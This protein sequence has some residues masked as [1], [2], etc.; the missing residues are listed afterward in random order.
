MKK[1]SLLI[2]LACSTLLLSSCNKVQANLP[3][4][5]KPLVDLGE[6]SIKLDHN[7]LSTIYETI[8]GGDAY[9][10]TVSDLLTSAIAE[11]VLGD[12]KVIV[13]DGKI[14]VVLVGYDVAYDDNTPA[15]KAEFIKAHKAYNNWKSSSFK[16]ILEDG[17]PTEADFEKRVNLIKELIKTQVITTLWNEANTTSYKRNNRFYE[18]LFARN[19]VEKLYK[20]TDGK[21][22]DLSNEDFIDDNPSYED[23]YIR[24]ESGE[25]NGFKADKDIPLFENLFTNGVLI[26]SKYDVNSKEGR[27]H[28]QNVLHFE[29]YEDYINNSVM[30]TI[31]KN[32]LVEQYVLQ[33]QFSAIG[34]TA[35]RKVNFIQVTNNNEKNGD[36]FFNEFVK[37]YFTDVKGDELNLSTNDKFEIASAAWKGNPNYINTLPEG[38]KTASTDLAKKTFGDIKNDNPSKGVVPGHD[39]GGYIENFADSRDFNYYK[40]TPYYNIVNDYSTLSNDIKTNNTTNYS[41]FTSIDSITYSP[42]VGFAIKEDANTVLDYTTYGWQTQDSSSLPETIKNKLYSYGFVNEWKQAEAKTDG[43]YNGAFLYEIANTGSYLLRKDTY[44]SLVDSVLW[45]ESGVYY[46]VQVEDI[47]ASSTNSIVDNETA[48]EEDKQSAEERFEI[49]AKSREAAY[50][51]ASGTTYTNNALTYY[52]EQCNIDYHDQDVYD[53]FVSTFPRLFE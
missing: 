38:L 40:N 10:S 33:E 19:Q 24:E 51:L 25:F 4:G 11:S 35:S 12:Y 29:Y 9:A 23:H 18:V 27:E 48:K 34:S 21:G 53:Y 30:P 7:T 2:T 16:L 28:I 31:M 20:V 47:I 44:N 8:K 52:L 45:E 1:K 43:Q 6:T 42:I 46:L 26:D 39:K 3:N 5:D 37:K 32:L 14:D 22:K 15:N 13:K 41:A 50:T 17:E 36:K 49:E